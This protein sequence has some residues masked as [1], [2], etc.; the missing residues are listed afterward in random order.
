MYSKTNQIKYARQVFDKMPQR[1]L[2]TWTTLISAYSKWGLANES[3]E[4]FRAMGVDGF[5]P[6]CYSFVSALSACATLGCLRSGKEIHGRVVRVEGE[7]NSFVE[8]SLVNFYGK[9]YS[10][11]GLANESLECFRAMGV[12]GFVPN[13]YSFVSALSACA[14]LGCLRSGKEIHGRVVRVEGELNSFVE[15]SLVNFYGKCG[16]FRSAVAVFE[17]IVDPNA[18]VVTGLVNLYAK[19]ADVDSA[20]QSFNEV[21]NPHLTAWTALIGGYIQ[22]GK[23]KEA[24][25]LFIK[26]HNSGEK[27][28]ERTF[29][30][31]LSNE[32]E[33]GKQLHSLIIKFGYLSFT[34]I[35][36]SAMDFYFK[37]GYATEALKVF[38]EMNEHDVVTWNALISG[39]M[40]AGFYDEAVK[41]LHDMLSKGFELNLHSYSSILSIC[42]DLPAI[43]WGKETHCCIVKLEFD[44][45]VVVGSALIDMYAKCGKLSNARVVFDNF[46]FK[47]IVSWNT[48]LV[49]YAH[50]G[51]AEKSLEIYDMMLKSGVTPN[52]ITFIGVLSAC[53]HSGLLKD[54]LHY[55]NSMI[56]DFGITP[57]T[58][59]L[60]CMVNLFSRKGLTKLA[61]DFI[62][63]CPA[64]PDKVVW[65]C[66][67]SGCKINK[68]FEL[69][70][71]AAEKILSID[72]DD[73]SAYV[74]LSNIYAELK[75]WDEIAIVRKVMKEKVL[76]KD[77]GYSW[78]ELMSK[79]Y[80]FTSAREAGSEGYFVSDVLNGLT[81]QLFDEGYVPSG[82]RQ[83]YPQV[84]EMLNDGRCEVMCVN[85][86][87]RL[88]HIPDKIHEKA[89]L[90]AGDI[91]LE[92]I[93]KEQMPS[94]EMRR[95]T[96]V[97]GARVLR[98]GRRLFTSP[99]EVIIRH[100]RKNVPLAVDDDVEQG[101]F[102]LLEHNRGGGLKKK[103][104]LNEK[105]AV[106]DEV[107]EVNVVTESTSAVPQNDANVTEPSLPVKLKTRRKKVP[108]VAVARPTRSNY[109]L[110]SGVMV[111]RGILKKQR[112]SLRTRR[113]GNPSTFLHLKSG[114]AKDDN[115]PFF[116]IKSNP[117]IHRSIRRSFREIQSRVVGL[118]QNVDS[119]RCNAN[120][121]V[122]ESDRCYREGGAVVSIEMSGCRKCYL[123][124]KRNGVERFRVQAGDVM[125]PC[126][127]NRVTRA[128]IWPSGDGSW[129]LEF[130]DRHDW[131]IFKELY[132]KCSERPAQVHA[133]QASIIPVPRV[134]EVSGKRI[135]TEKS[136]SVLPPND[137]TVTKLSSVLPQKN[138]IVIGLASVLPQNDSVVTESTS[139]VPQ[140]DANVTEPSLPV[141]L[142]TRRKKV[143]R[144]AV[145]R[146]TRSNYQLRSGVM[147]PRGIL[148]KQR[149]SLRTRRQGNP[150]TFLHLKSGGAKDD[151]VPFFPIKSNPVIHRS[152]RRS[153]REIQSRVVGLTQNVDSARCNANILV[154]ESDRCYREGGAV[155]SIEM[156]G[157]R[158]CYLVVKRN[159]VERFRVQAGDVMKPCFC[160]RVTRAIIWPSGD[161]SWRLEFPD[162]HDWSIF[163]ELYR[164]CSERPAQVHAS[165]ASIIPVPRVS[166][167]S[168]YAEEKCSPF[169]L[170]DSY[171]RS[172]SDEVTRVLEKSFNAERDTPVDEDTFE[173]IIDAY[174]RGI[175]GS[176]ADYS[177]V[178][179]AID[180]CSMLA[181]NEVLKA[182]YGYWMAKRKK[183]RSPLVRVFQFYKPRKPERLNFK[184]VLRKKR[185]FRR[186]GSQSGRGKQLTFLNAFHETITS[187]E[188]DIATSK[189]QE[190]ETAAERAEQVAIAKRQRAQLKMEVADLLTYKAVIAHKIAE[191]RATSGSVDGDINDDH[192]FF[193]MNSSG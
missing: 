13:C 67:L 174:E 82:T 112:S 89:C 123:V 95:T 45:N 172:T 145:A 115:V 64:K 173:K 144:V 41:L 54:G 28:N 69:G 84:V 152:I 153:F 59:H 88:C 132:R 162:R 139:A 146:P 50:H 110:R 140:N 169:K 49:G 106:V 91:V 99:Q 90:A 83:V 26:L 58:D 166:E 142:K 193:P 29:A 56:K 158:K 133:S 149:S 52:G 33:I 80:L 12:D 9:S 25:S 74:M 157:C 78:I 92:V 114:G 46:N 44:S 68:D 42:G 181:S 102:E 126:F 111:P 40:N 94:V 141:K 186:R 124:V 143:P 76:K 170:P 70:K 11:W 135:K 192:L 1:N 164:K 131:S 23:Y 183:K 148:K 32:I 150:S 71:L 160:N 151:N 179:L 134:S 22:H 117:V 167:V 176:P 27:P 187:E 15:N 165:Q 66:L 136:P 125:K 51:H 129:R 155:V 147:V 18:F 103:R 161:G 177:D 97:F 35:G 37:T 154:I 180:R 184:T 159:G 171:I 96:R 31:V 73:V 182:V 63:K 100:M 189:V 47:N 113:Q 3:L 168:G 137:T 86:T 156:S 116:P 39:H 36:N 118:T 4:C 79:T 98:S 108:R 21:R 34:I 20:Q 109:Q 87:K 17:G 190:A 24:S 61:Y 104:N 8:N 119:A 127:C 77:T 72:P 120:I 48:M 6:N 175:Y 121:L 101:W 38:D 122:I 178:T 93:R 185:S 30:T 128:I 14:T 16:V 43:N 10:K 163:K 65:R 7:L 138:T 57:R 107:L 130:P 62:S 53:G 19:C 2:I 191:A 81:E 85:G 105:S 60:A 5:V 188:A 55:F 75:M